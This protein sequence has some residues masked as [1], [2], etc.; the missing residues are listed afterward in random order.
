VFYEDAGGRILMSRKA[1]GAGSAPSIAA[2]GERRVAAGAEHLYFNPFPAAPTEL[3]IERVRTRLTFSV[4]GAEAPLELEASA[5][6]DRRPAV[7]LSLPLR[8]DLLVWSAHDLMAH[9]RRFDYAIPPLRAFGMV[10]NSGRYAYDLVIVDDQRRMSHGDEGAPENWLGFGRAVHAPV[11]GVVVSVR[12]DQPDNGQWNPEALNDDP[13][14]L[15]GNHIVIEHDGA[16]VVLAH[17]K[18]GSLR[19]GAGDRVR[20]GDQIANVG[21]SGS[22]LFPHLHVQVMDAPTSRGEGLPSVFENF[23]RLGGPR[24]ATVRRGPIGTGEYVRARR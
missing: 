24:P 5:A 4:A 14:I 19:V 10:S 17:L 8:G 7:A 9:H 6:L 15:F 3:A 22:S 18:Q 23:E 20:A 11:D 2:I 12:A 1:D 13:N 16:Y 21:H